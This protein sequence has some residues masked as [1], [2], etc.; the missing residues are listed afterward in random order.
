[1]RKQSY[2]P[3]TAL[4]SFMQA[5]RKNGKRTHDFGRHRAGMHVLVWT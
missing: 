1:L 4:N 2:D 3:E 5:I